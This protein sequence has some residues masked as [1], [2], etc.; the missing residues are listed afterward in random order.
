MVDLNA[1]QAAIRAGYSA[2]TAG[3]IGHENL[4]KPEVVLG[5]QAARRA[6]QERT[7]ITA[8]IV[9]REIALIALADARKL[10]EGKKG[11]C[12]HCWGEGHRAQYTVGEQ[13]RR[14]EDHAKKGGLPDSFDTEG[15][16]GYNPHRPP[17]PECP[18]CMGDGRLHVVFKDTRDFGPA[19]V[20]LYAGIKTT[21]D[22]VEVKMHSKMDAIEK[23]AKHLGVYE[24]DNQQKADPVAALIARIATGNGNGF[25]PVVNDPEHKGPA[26]ASPKGLNPSQAEEEE[27]N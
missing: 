3:S 15:G 13:N 17:H 2:D 25:I 24:L 26:P 6:Q 27:E 8:D 12:R 18:D 14:M 19:E 5:I 23:L 10:V 21:K 11:C 16:I 7:G 20:A 22:G 4:Q 1:T 9:L